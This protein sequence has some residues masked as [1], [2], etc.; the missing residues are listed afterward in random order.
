M[1]EEFC[2][3]SGYFACALCNILLD[4]TFRRFVFFLSST[5]DICY[6]LGD[7]SFFVC[8][9]FRLIEKFFAI[10]KQVQTVRSRA[11]TESDD[12]DTRLR[13]LCRLT[14]FRPGVAQFVLALLQ[15]V[16]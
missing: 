11:E 16:I 7:L 4:K 8:N 9:I 6:N 12:K 10:E 5:T 14:L 3:L 15:Q 2:F 1:V 13:S